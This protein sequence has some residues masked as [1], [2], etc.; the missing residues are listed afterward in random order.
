MFIIFQGYHAEYVDVCR[1]HLESEYQVQIR[2]GRISLESSQVVQKLKDD[3]EKIQV[4]IQIDKILVY[5]VSLSKNTNHLL[6]LLQPVR[7]DL[8]AYFEQVLR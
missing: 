8:L 1:R 3:F 5:N 2:Y 4:E 6:K 7:A